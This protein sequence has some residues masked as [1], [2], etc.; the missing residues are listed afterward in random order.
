MGNEYPLHQLK[1][2]VDEDKSLIYARITDVVKASGLLVRILAQFGEN[3][4]S[5][6]GMQEGNL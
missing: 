6:F 2:I 3:A 5:G 4:H 1:A